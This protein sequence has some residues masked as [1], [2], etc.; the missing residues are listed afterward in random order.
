M[1][2]ALVDALRRE[3]GS[4][5]VRVAEPLARYTSLRVGGPADLLVL[6]G[7]LATLRRALS[8]AWSHDLPCR[9]LGG[10]SNVLVSDAGVPGLVIL[11][12]VRGIEFGADRVW[13]GSG[14]SLA[15]LAR[16]AVDQGLRGLEW[17]TGI[18]GSVGGAVAGN[19]GA[20]GGD[21]ASV[22]VEARMLVPGQPHT[23]TAAEA[24][25][26]PEQFDFGYRTSVLRRASRQAGGTPQPVV[27]SAAFRLEPG[28]PAE[29]AERV[30]EIAA[31]R[32]ARQPQGATCGSVFKNP[33]GDYAGR[34]IEAAGLKGTSQG[35]A[36][37]S[38]AHAN[39][40]VNLGGATSADVKALI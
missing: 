12:R 10:G 19:A 27:L 36:A 34:L 9:V 24:H 15:T 23:R 28:N 40:V 17:A 4:H 37:I 39:F 11:N 13:A 33:P 29:L 3:L 14:T 18:P 31:T 25:W 21:V 8:L 16:R 30:S 38:P 32:R 20:W 6:T 22:L 2:P 26:T 35:A 7:D 5:A 1:T